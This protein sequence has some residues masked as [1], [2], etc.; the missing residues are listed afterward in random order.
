MKADQII[1]G[2][3]QYSQEQEELGNNFIEEFVDGFC[4]LEE[5]DLGP[6]PIVDSVGDTEGGGEYS[7]VIRHFSEHNVYI[8][9]TGCYTSYHGCEWEE[10]Y[11]EVIPVEKSIIVYNKV[12]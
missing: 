5:L 3:N 8:K 10:I 2:L 6:C 7:H 1:E 9:V 11:E 4:D 12:N